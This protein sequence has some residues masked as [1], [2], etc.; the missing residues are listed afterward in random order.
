MRRAF[1]CLFLLER[2]KKMKRLG[3]YNNPEIIQESDDLMMTVVKCPY[4]GHETTVGQLVGISGYHGCPHC[5][6]V[7]GGLRQIVTYLQENDYP[8]YSKGLFYQDGFEK[9]RQNYISVL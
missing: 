8:T 2:R 5:Y 9:N 6:F 7:S 3:M 4:C 1:A